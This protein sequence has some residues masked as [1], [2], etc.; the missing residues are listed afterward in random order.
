MDCPFCYKNGKLSKDTEDRVFFRN[1][2]WFALLAAPY[3]TRGHTILAA[4]CNDPSHCP[5][6]MIF[7]E[8]DVVFKDLTKALH[9]HYKPKDILFASLRGNVKHF[10]IHFIPLWEME[11]IEWRTE[12]LYEKGHLFEFLGDIEKRGV[13]HSMQE[14]IKEGWSQEEQSIH[15]AKQLS[16][17]VN[18]L[19]D[20][21]GY[22]RKA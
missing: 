3:Y 18:K 5:Q 13:A 4:V 6:K 11:E 10:H 15:I 20:I 12:K 9:N 8:I 2:K 19:R 7:D 14:R 22:K 16:R 21:T 17:D 1:E